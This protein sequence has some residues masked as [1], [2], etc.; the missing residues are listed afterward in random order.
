[1]IETII[2]IQPRVSTG[3]GSGKT[4]D[5]IV[6]DLAKDLESRLPL[7]LDKNTGNPELFKKTEAGSLPSLTTVL[8]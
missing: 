8:L 7:L 1:M 3:G 2:S 6:M 5:E 4:S